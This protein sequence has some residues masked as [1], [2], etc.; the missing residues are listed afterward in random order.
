MKKIDK[1]QVV[2]IAGLAASVVGMI[3]STW[4]GKKDNDQTLKKLVDERLQK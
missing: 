4:V 2:R 3:A 1:V